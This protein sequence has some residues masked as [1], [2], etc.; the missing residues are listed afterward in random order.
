MKGGEVVFLTEK[1]QLL[2]SGIDDD[3]NYNISK[4][5]TGTVKIGVVPV[6]GMPG[7]PAPKGPG[8]GRPSGIGGLPKEGGPPAE[9]RD[10][11]KPKE[12][13]PKLKDFPAKYKNPEES[14]L[15]YEF[16]GGKQTYP[17][18]LK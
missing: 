14:G 17:I 7:V 15:S 18:D 11:Y 3:G 13:D 4:V 6:E 16:P 8:G 5:P 9:F 1:G 12:A 2:R 10:I